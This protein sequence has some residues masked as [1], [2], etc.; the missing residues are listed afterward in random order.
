MLILTPSWKAI[1]LE[2]MSSFGASIQVIKHQLAIWR[3]KFLPSRMLFLFSELRMRRIRANIDMENEKFLGCVVKHF[4]DLRNVLLWL[5][6]PSFAAVLLRWPIDPLGC[7]SWSI[8]YGKK[9]STETRTSLDSMSF[10][11]Q[12][13]CRTDDQISRAKWI[14]IVRA[15]CAVRV[16]KKM[17][18][19]HL[20]IEFSASFRALC[21]FVSS[22]LMILALFALK[23]KWKIMRF[24]SSLLFNLYEF[25]YI[26]LPWRNAR[27]K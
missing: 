27:W 5:F 25:V 19:K 3:L 24:P 4:C 23:V 7:S 10:N 13:I 18:N 6:L 14:L 15:L 20:L 1:R 16:V 21:C 8:F 9:R 26:F 11:L 2:L 12:Q 17:G 22:F